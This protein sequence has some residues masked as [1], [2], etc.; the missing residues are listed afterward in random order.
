MKHTDRTQFSL[1]AM[2]AFIL[3]LFML[4][5]ACSQGESTHTGEAP[6]EDAA[7]HAG[8]ED[9]SVRW[10][11]S[12]VEAGG[13][14]VEVAAGGEI[15]LRLTLP[16]VVASN[17]DTVTHV[18]PKAAGIVRSIHKHL[19]EKAE[20]GDLLCV[21][22]SV[23]LGSAV[24]AFVGSR[25]LAEAALTTL[26][27]ERVLFEHRL[28]MTERVLQGSIEVNQRI[29][30]REKALQE[31]AVST[32]RPLLEAEKA[33]QHSRLEKERQLTDLRAQRDTRL[34]ALEVTLTERCI[35]RDAARN[36][37][38]AMGLERGPLDDLDADSPLMAGTYE[39]HSP[40]FGIV[41]GR[42]ITVGEF[43]DTQTKLYT[44]E[45][46]SRVWILA[47]AFEEQVRSVRTGQTGSIRLDAFPGRVFPGQV[48]LIGYEVDSRSRA[49]TVRFEIDNP[50]LPDWPE[51]FPLRPGMYGTV[52]LVI[53]QT[54]A[55]V[56]VPESSIVHEAGG[57]FVFA[58]TA[59]GTFERRAVELGPPSGALV[60]VIR[61]VEP[62][63]EIVVAGT[64]RLKSALRQG[65]LGGGHN[66]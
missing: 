5:S 7:V 22:D 30:E 20:A 24:A 41:S 21:I 38:L 35:A 26:K 12:Q 31:E 32:M 47:S 36:A 49:L 64:F 52:D 40:R 16:A 29:Q 9:D 37:L 51:A 28:T 54:Q 8:G 23:E 48:N 61:G 60:E 19:G 42:H 63:D 46:L 17:A 14:R 10:T 50:D 44:M 39:I 33:L 13:V 55:R 15:A 53:G 56:V 6:A 11:P 4:S 34:L 58:R 2:H 25:S 18:N 43:V 65:E 45:D 57:E 3:G 27:Q 62:G 66:H 59:P 1:S